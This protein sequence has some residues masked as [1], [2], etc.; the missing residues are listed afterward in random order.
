ME[1]IAL[2]L[3][4]TG[5]RKDRTMDKYTSLL[6]AVP[7]FRSGLA[8][9]LDIGATFDAYNS[10]ATSAEADRAAIASDWYSV[11]A[12]LSRSLNRCAARI[13]Y[14]KKDVERRRP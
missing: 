2:A 5:R 6:Y 13:G 12:D 7:S 10:Y 1:I 14:E 9:T 8:R 4:A 11:W 3:E